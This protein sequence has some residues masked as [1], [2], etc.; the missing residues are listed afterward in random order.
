MDFWL[1][2]YLLKLFGKRGDVV[3]LNIMTYRLLVSFRIFFHNFWVPH[4]V[5]PLFVNSFGF[6]FDLGHDQG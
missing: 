6:E 1:L 2:F 3:F 5:P 4:S